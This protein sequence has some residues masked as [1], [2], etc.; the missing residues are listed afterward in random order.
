MGTSSAAIFRNLAAFRRYLRR[1]PIGYAFGPGNSLETCPMAVWAQT[2]DRSARVACTHVAWDG[3]FSSGRVE[4]V[5]HWQEEFTRRSMM[6]TLATGERVSR[7]RAIEILEEIA[8]AAHR[9]PLR[10]FWRLLEMY[11]DLDRPDDNNN[12]VPSA[13]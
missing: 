10:P 12:P 9:R 2:F 8:P 13:G 4:R 5:A 7:D 11:P 1:L 3:S 6:H